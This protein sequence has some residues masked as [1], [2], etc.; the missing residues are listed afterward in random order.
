MTLII[1]VTNQTLSSLILNV[2]RHLGVDISENEMIK[3]LVSLAFGVS[4]KAPLKVTVPWWRANDVKEEY[5][6]VEEIARIYGYHNIPAVLPTG[7][8]PV[9]TKDKELIWEK[10][11]KHALAGLGFTEVY[12][13]SMVS[14]DTLKVSKT[15]TSNAIKIDNPLNEDMEYMRVA[16]AP[17]ILQNVADNIKNFSSQKIF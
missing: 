11:A 9:V 14:K 15:G 10:N 16:L 17:Q 13:Y 8:I 12:N 2:N 4:K 1:K 3:I 5:D 6:L 7:E